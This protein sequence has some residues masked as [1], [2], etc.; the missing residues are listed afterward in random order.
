MDLKTNLEGIEKDFEG[1][2]GITAKNLGTGEE[3][4]INGDILFPLASVFKIPV[5]VTLYRQVDN[6]NISLDDKIEMTDYARVPGSGVL[7]ELSPGHEMTIRDYRT[8]MMLISDNTATDMVV[9]LLGK[10]N[11]NNT[12]I[13]LGLKDTRITTCR[14]ILFSFLG[15]ADVDTTK[16]TIDLWNETIKKRREEGYTPPEE[17]RRKMDNVTTPNDMMKLLEKI[18]KGEAAS[19]SSCDEILELMKKC[20]TGKNRIS[21]NIPRDEIKI[22]HKTGTIKGVVNDVGIVFPKEKEPYI[23][24]V[25]TKDIEGEPEIYVPTGEKAIATASKIVYDSFVN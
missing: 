25:F 23:I 4:I 16:W 2:I 5:I 17:L 15:L 20:Q 1:T 3:A 14:E 6:R 18:Y 13:E 21:K 10:E 9:D 24:C 7:K 19:R 8:L 22:A 12:M 11:I